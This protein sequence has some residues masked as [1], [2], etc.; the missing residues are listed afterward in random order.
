[1]VTVRWNISGKTKYVLWWEIFCTAAS[2]FSILMFKMFVLVI[3]FNILWYM[4]VMMIH[5]A[6]LSTFRTDDSALNEG[7]STKCAAN[8]FAQAVNEIITGV[9][10]AI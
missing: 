10:L 8:I 1:M 4:T 7:K 2:H 6:L 5:S 3:C 9:T